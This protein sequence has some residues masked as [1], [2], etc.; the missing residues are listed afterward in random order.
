MAIG[1]HGVGHYVFSKLPLERQRQEIAG[2]LAALSRILGKPVTT[3]CYPYGG[4]H[5]FTA[6]TVSLLREAGTR[7]AFDVNARDITSDDLVRT[8]HALPRY[9]CNMFP[10][11]LASTGA[12][13]AQQAPGPDRGDE[14]AAGSYVGRP[15]AA[16]VSGRVT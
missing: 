3:F 11:G 1:S 6:E 8:P 13:R 10:S 4:R 2:S 7:F 14:G 16:M 9:D 12:T 5:T 15:I